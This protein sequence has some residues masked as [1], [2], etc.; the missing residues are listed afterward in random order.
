M[1][2][3]LADDPA[4]LAIA[5][6]TALSRQHV[7]GALHAVWSWFDRQT[8]R[9]TAPGVGHAL[10]DELAGAADFSKAMETVGWL[11]VTE[12]GLFIP[13]FGRF[14]SQSA[15]ARALTARRVAR[16][17]ARS[18][19]ADGVTKTLPEQSQSQRTAESESEKRSE[20]SAGAGEPRPPTACK[21]ISD[22]NR[23]VRGKTLTLGAILTETAGAAGGSTNGGRVVFDIQEL[24]AS[25]G[26]DESLRGVVAKLVDVRIVRDLAA[27]FDAQRG[28]IQRPGGWWRD[29]LRRRGVRAV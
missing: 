6:A 16:H 18:G 22:G 12:A 21:A 3:D 4:V 20:Q 13:R 9:G 7:V 29:Q 17:R 8:A 28:T 19:N 10:V 1:R 27:K 2:H 5:A 14:M 11:R 26:C 23:Q 25:R 15:K 24:M